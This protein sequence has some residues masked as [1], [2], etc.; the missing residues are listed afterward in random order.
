M[1][2][3]RVDDE[4]KLVLHNDCG[5]HVNLLPHLYFHSTNQPFIMF[6]RAFKQKFFFMAEGR[7]KK[8]NCEK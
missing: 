6:A 1:Q 8:K 2:L 7:E 4:E 3:I 5:I